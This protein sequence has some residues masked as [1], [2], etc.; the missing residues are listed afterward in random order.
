MTPK[1]NAIPKPG[2]AATKLCTEL[3]LAEF[4]PDFS[5]YRLP[6]LTIAANTQCGLSGHPTNDLMLLLIKSSLQLGKFP[7]IDIEDYWLPVDVAADLMVQLALTPDRRQVYHLMPDQPLTW[8]DVVSQI[9][10]EVDVVDWDAWRTS[11]MSEH[12]LSD[13]K[14]IWGLTLDGL[15][16][17]IRG[18]R[19]QNRHTRETLAKIGARL[20]ADSVSALTTSLEVLRSLDPAFAAFST[21]T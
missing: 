7:R 5:V 10:S 14:E 16:A 4:K 8:D 3:A 19:F 17:E 21:S 13:L 9:E 2:Y 1:S 6:R 15:P 18:Q 11:L 20:P 12:N